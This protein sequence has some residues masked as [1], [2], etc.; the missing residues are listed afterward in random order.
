MLS[1]AFTLA[2]SFSRPRQKSIF[3]QSISYTEPY[4]TLQTLLGSQV[5]SYLAAVAAPTARP[6]RNE[7]PTGYTI[8]LRPLRLQVPTSYHMCQDLFELNSPVEF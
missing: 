6:L 4:G 5:R 8:N 2:S 3:R 7:A 1:R